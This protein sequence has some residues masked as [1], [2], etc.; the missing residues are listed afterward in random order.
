MVT[1]RRDS[2]KDKIAGA[3]FNEMRQLA[4][5]NNGRTS[6]EEFTTP[7]QFRDRTGRK[8]LALRESDGI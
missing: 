5:E 4:D 7:R 8:F 2:E 6:G 3:G 1:V